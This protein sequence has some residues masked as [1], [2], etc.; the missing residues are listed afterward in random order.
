[1]KFEFYLSQDTAYGMD[2]RLIALTYT[3]NQTEV[4]QEGVDSETPDDIRGWL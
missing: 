1:M 3:A 2:D 4:L